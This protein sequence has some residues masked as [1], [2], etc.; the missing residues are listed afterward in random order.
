ME[1]VLER[2]SGGGGHP[3]GWG[4]DS[5]SRQGGGGALVWSGLLVDVNEELK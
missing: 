3:V 1:G 5:G 4:E 2:G